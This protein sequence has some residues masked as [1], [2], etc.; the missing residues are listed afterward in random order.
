MAC[1]LWCKP[2]AATQDTV[3]LFHK[4]SLA[5]STGIM[6]IHSFFA[7][8]LEM[9]TAPLNYRLRLGYYSVGAGL[10]LE[11]GHISGTYLN[12]V[13]KA[14]TI[15]QIVT[16]NAIYRWDNSWWNFT[17]FE[18]PEGRERLLWDVDVGY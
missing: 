4:R 17:Q 10:E 9:K 1:A 15:H 11:M 16:V 3:N 18:R 8:T 14:P 2:S 7:P 5:Y 13:L 12:S 6:G